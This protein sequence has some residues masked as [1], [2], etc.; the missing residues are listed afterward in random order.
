MK[1]ENKETGRK[2]H[3]HTQAVFEST[4]KYHNFLFQSIYMATFTTCLCGFNEKIHD[5]EAIIGYFPF[6]SEF[7][8]YLYL[9]QKRSQKSSSVSFYLRQNDERSRFYQSCCCD[10]LLTFSFFWKIFK[11]NKVQ[12]LTF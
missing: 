7:N 2:L 1:A 3:T 5:I 11:D 4:S 6:L 8:Y 12:I 10:V 9:N